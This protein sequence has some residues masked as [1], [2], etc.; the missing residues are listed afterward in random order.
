MKTIGPVTAQGVG[1]DGKPVP[2][3]GQAVVKSA[4]A[5]APGMDSEIEDA[6]NGA[7]FAVRVE[8]VVPAVLPSV[9]E[10]K[11]LLLELFAARKTMDAINA[12]AEALAERIK[13]GESINAVAASV[14]AQV[15]TIKA[16]DRLRASQDPQ[17][18]QTMPRELLEKM[19]GV[20]PGE[21]FIVDGG[22]PRVI[23]AHLDAVR[24]GSTPQV[25]RII[26]AQRPQLTAQIFRD[27]QNQAQERAVKAMKARTDLA[28]ARNAI[29]VDPD[30]AARLDGKAA[31]PA[32]KA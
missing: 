5:L 14:G 3:A 9:T 6:G 16:L 29:G 1:A 28:R 15:G 23:V 24:P 10:L 11:P 18:S 27:M 21:T 12:R 17:I 32:P 20:K 31:A 30:L 13:K 7:S 4:F 19:F 26:E 25:A 2:G 22:P 8:R